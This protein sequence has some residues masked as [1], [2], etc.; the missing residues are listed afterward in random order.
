M[1]TTQLT[2]VVGIGYGVHMDLTHMTPKQID[3]QL[4]DLYWE[5]AKLQQKQEVVLRKVHEAVG[6]RQSVRSNFKWA[7]THTQALEALPA[8]VANQD[9]EPW[10]HKAA[11][12]AWD[13]WE[14][15]QEEVRR[16]Q[17]EIALRNDEFNRRGGWTRAFIVPGGHVHSSMD[18]SS[19]YP[20]T[21][22]GWMPE[23]SGDDED[24][25]VGKAGE[26]AC[27]V[28]Y[29]TA[30]VDV[31]SRPTSLWTEDEKKEMAEKAVRKAALEEKKAKARA[32]APQVSGEPIEVRDHTGY[33]CTLKTERAASNWLLQEVERY[34]VG[35]S[36][37]H[38][39]RMTMEDWEANINLVARLWAEKRGVEVQVVRDE[40][41]AKV[42]KK[43][44]K[45]GWQTVTR[46][47]RSPEP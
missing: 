24:E 19:C 7:L 40:I 12:E 18:C 15:L 8:R 45:G 30:P 22:F 43:I 3:A 6:D 36:P 23:L 16:V 28:C 35:E 2:P 5:N 9:L 47:W 41:T 31:I 37:W 38:P 39:E 14:D 27:T 26:R 20:T 34:I 13:V 44:A 1:M 21:K 33:L 10:D 11:V 29:P 17:G 42:L 46:T 25:I 4:S 32:N